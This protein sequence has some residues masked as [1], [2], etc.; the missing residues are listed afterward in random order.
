MKELITKKAIE[1]RTSELAEQ[2]NRD[3]ADKKDVLVLC[4][5]KGAVMFFADLVRQLNFDMELDFCAPQSYGDGTISSGK[6]DMKLAPFT[7]IKGRDILLVEDIVDTGISLEF[8]KKYLVDSG[9]KSVKVAAL[10]DKPTRRRVAVFADYVG[11]SIEDKFVIG[12]G[13]DKMQ[14]FRNLNGIFV[15]E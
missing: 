15:V 4:A 14:K 11:F 2:I 12:F 13:L 10:L 5:L 6:V 3:F 1:E 8:C 9:A 7:T